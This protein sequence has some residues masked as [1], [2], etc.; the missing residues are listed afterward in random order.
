MAIEKLSF[1]TVKCDFCGSPL[2]DYAGE[3]CRITDTKEE[4]MRMAI[5]KNFCYKNKKWYCPCCAKKLCVSNE[6]NIETRDIL[7]VWGIQKNT[8]SNLKK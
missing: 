6:L 2:E 7:S 3:I 4:A 5:I 8:V 1:Y